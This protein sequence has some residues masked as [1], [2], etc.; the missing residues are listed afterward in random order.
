MALESIISAEIRGIVDEVDFL[1]MRGDG[2]HITSSYIDINTT[3]PHIYCIAVYIHSIERLD[4]VYYFGET[5]LLVGKSKIDNIIVTFDL[6]DPN[7][8]DNLI[9]SILMVSDRSTD[10]IQ[11][12]M[13][14]GKINFIK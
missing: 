10:T 11:K 9:A 14:M 7:S 8:I 2:K 4:L 1:S 6:H 3:H 13:S 5:G 12:I